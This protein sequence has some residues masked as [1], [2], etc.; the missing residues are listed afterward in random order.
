MRWTASD[1]SSGLAAVAEDA[2]TLP[3]GSLRNR[4]RFAE[5]LAQSRLPVMVAGA[6][7]SKG[8]ARQK[9]A[10]ASTVP[11]KLLPGGGGGGGAAGTV[12]STV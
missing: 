9:V 2:T 8:C 5:A 1:S 3:S 12:T 6:V 11:V 4:L 7:T 10:A